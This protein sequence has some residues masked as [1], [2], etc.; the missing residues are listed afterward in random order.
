[1][2]MAKKIS[3][4]LKREK[5]GRRISLPQALLEFLLHVHA[6]TSFF[7]HQAFCEDEDEEM[8]WL[9]LCQMRMKIAREMA[10]L[11]GELTCQETLVDEVKI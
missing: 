11:M 3:S 1:M 5:G 10:R 6:R 7:F 9:Y 2:V 8:R 4:W